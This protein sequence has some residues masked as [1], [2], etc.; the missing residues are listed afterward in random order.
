VRS[1]SKR[2]SSSTRNS[3]SNGTK[4]FSKPKKK[5]RKHF[6]NLRNV[7][8]LRLRAIDRF[9]ETSYHW[10][11]SSAPSSSTL[12]KFNKIWPSKRSIKTHTR[13]KLGANNSRPRREKNTWRKDKRKS[14]LQKL[15]WFKSNKMKWMLLKRNSRQTLTKGWSSEKQSITS[16]S[17]DTKTSRKRLRTNRTLRESSLRRRSRTRTQDHRQLVVRV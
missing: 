5:M 2:I 3:T 6:L 16:C 15:N 17:K 8:P 9:L 7:T 12:N 4:T 10:H 11:S 1:A 14:L 13:S